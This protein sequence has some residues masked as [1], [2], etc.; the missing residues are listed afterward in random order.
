MPVVRHREVARRDLVEHFVYLAE[1]V[2][3]DT[4]ERFLA[5]AQAPFEDLARQPLMG[6]PLNL[7]RPELTKIRKWRMR[8]F[9]NHLVFYE[10]RSDGVTVVRVLHAA[11]DWWGLFGVEGK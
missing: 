5:Q 6:A 9:E 1:N 11:S 2:G 10:P 8:H 3:L 4:A 7:K